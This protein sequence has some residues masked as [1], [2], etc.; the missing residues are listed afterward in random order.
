MLPVRT[1]LP[2]PDSL[3]DGEIVARVVAGERRLFELIMRRHNERVYRAVRSIL[4]MRRQPKSSWCRR[5]SRQRNSVGGGI[6]PCGW[7]PC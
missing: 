4:R 5:P 7:R 6:Q 2:A 3:A 1:A